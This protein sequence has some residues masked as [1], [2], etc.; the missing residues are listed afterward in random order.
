M[1]DMFDVKVPPLSDF[2]AYLPPGK[3]SLVFIPVA[4]AV[5]G[6]SLATAGVR[7]REEIIP[8]REP[9]TA[10]PL[11]IGDWRGVEQAMEQIY[12]EASNR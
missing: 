9:L 7:D 12:L 8:I 10:F 2:Q 4:V 1:A 5:V 3:P 11:R 6:T